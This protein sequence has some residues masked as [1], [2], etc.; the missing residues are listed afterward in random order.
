MADIEFLEDLARPLGNVVVKP[1]FGGWGIWAE[2]RMFALVA[3]DTLYFKVDAV[4]GPAFEER[5]LPRFAYETKDGRRTVMSYARA[6]EEVF[7]DPEIF[8]LWAREAIGAARRSAAAPKKGA[9]RRR[10][11]P[12]AAPSGD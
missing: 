6:P 2:G 12:P 3:Y 9:S 7:D 11:S 10:R 1:M 8:L 4:N 5:S